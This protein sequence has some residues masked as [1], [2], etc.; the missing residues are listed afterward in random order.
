[1]KIDEKLLQTPF[2]RVTHLR[3][4]SLIY[5]LIIVVVS[6]AGATWLQDYRQFP[7]IVFFALIYPAEMIVING[8]GGWHEANGET[9]LAVP[10]FLLATLMWYGLVEAARFVWCYG[11]P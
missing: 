8:A 1:M 4:S 5:A 3:A 6:M 7:W 9:W 2:S 11:R 10:I